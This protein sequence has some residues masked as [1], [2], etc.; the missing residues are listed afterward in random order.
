MRQLDLFAWGAPPPPPVWREWENHPRFGF[1]QYWP[2]ECGRTHSGII[3]SF[4]W[5]MTSLKHWRISEVQQ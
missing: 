1:R 4:P 3:L 5:E 2:C